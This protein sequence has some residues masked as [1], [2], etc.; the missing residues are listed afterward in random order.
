M[1]LIYSWKLFLLI[2]K[3]FTIGRNIVRNPRYVLYIDTR[4]H[5]ERRPDYVLELCWLH[6]WH[7]HGLLVCGKIYIPILRYFLS[8]Q[9][10]RTVLNMCHT[11]DIYGLDSY[12]INTVMIS[13]I[14]DMYLS[15]ETGPKAIKL[16]YTSLGKNSRM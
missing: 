12:T 5:Y 8:K 13:I 10:V 1:E 9:S 15:W 14:C 2:L 11:Y 7:E 3:V 6:I 4:I 16:T